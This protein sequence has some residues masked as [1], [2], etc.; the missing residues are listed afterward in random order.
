MKIIKECFIA[1]LSIY[2]LISSNAIS[3][4]EINIVCDGC[5]LN[6]MKTKAKR[7]LENSIPPEEEE[8]E[9]Q[10]TVNFIDFINDKEKTFNV[11]VYVGYRQIRDRDFIVR[12]TVPSDKFKSDIKNVKNERNKVKTEVESDGIPI[13]I[14]SS[15][16]RIPGRSY[17]VNDLKDYIKANVQTAIATTKLQS[18]ASSMGLIKTPLPNVFKIPLDA[19]GYVEVE[20]N[21]AGGLTFEVKLKKVIDSD[22]NTLPLKKSEVQYQSFRISPGASYIDDLNS[23]LTMWGMSNK[24]VSTGTVKIHDLVCDDQ[25]CVCPDCPEDKQ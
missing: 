11:A 20:L 25:G 12:E 22:N 8:G 15:A 17:V 9:Y 23:V 10:L 3:A 21:A 13:N 7:S 5:T 19:G 24:K 16:W 18:Y 1:G 14:V 2:L 4:Y 6:E